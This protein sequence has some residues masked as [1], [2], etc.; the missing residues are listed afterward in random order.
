M[1]LQFF[2]SPDY[3]DRI[4]VMNTLNDALNQN[5]DNNNKFILVVGTERPNLHD[6]Q[7]INKGY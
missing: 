3:N 5:I 7:A 2:N 4:N 6:V 1:L